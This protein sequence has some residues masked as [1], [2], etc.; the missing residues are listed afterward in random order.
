MPIIKSKRLHHRFR[1]LL[2]AGLFLIAG[3][4]SLPHHPGAGDNRFEVVFQYR[5]G[6]ARTICVAADFND[7]S[8][9]SDCMSREHDLWVLRTL[10]APGRYRYMFVVDGR[11]WLEDPEALFSEDSGFGQR[12]SILLVP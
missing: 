11:R 9:T 5:S 4:A 7:W 8:T 6:S 2:A 1:L 12:N 3:C 10:L